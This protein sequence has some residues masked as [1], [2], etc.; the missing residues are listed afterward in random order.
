MG[1]ELQ[2]A[3]REVQEGAADRVGTGLLS[4]S[5]PLSVRVNS[6]VI[7]AA[8]GKM[9]VRWES[10]TRQGNRERREGGVAL[11]LRMALQQ[12]LQPR[13]LWTLTVFLLPQPP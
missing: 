8:L 10:E 2:R 9:V 7:T 11:T 1:T 5:I 3:G 13:L 12:I 4:L 6:G